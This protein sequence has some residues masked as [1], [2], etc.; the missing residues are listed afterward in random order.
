MHNAVIII[1]MSLTIKFHKVFQISKIKKVC[2]K[3]L[4]RELCYG[5][6]ILCNIKYSIHKFSGVLFS[7]ILINNSHI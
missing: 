4:I 2:I 3:L 7:H 5:T 1:S 6:M